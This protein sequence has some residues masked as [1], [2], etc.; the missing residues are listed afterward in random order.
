MCECW[1]NKIARVQHGRMCIYQATSNA[2]YSVPLLTLSNYIRLRRQFE[3]PQVNDV[4]FS[5][6]ELLVAKLSQELPPHGVSQ[7]PKGEA[8]RG[9]GGAS[10]GVES[11]LCII[12]REH[13]W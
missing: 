2:N 8:E 10:S 13:R 5:S 1:G 4:S 6:S 12:G 9:C 3:E 11:C 7:K